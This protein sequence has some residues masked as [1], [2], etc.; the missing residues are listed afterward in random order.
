MRQVFTSTEN[1]LWG[2]E[3][4][5]DQGNHPELSPQEASRLGP[6][7]ES[8]TNL[9]TP[10]GKGPTPALQHRPR[11]TT[12][13]SNTQHRNATNQYLDK[14]YYDIPV[15]HQRTK[16]TQTAIGENGTKETI[17]ESNDFSHEEEIPPLS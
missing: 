4:S 9:H 12:T 8:R 6:E 5:D 15:S 10:L 13:L 2:D 1:P 11:P 7:K 17:E 14:T 3:P 16:P